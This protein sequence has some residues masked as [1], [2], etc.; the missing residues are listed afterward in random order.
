MINEISNLVIELPL[1]KKNVAKSLHIDSL[2]QRRFN[3]TNRLFQAGKVSLLELQ[4]AQTEKNNATR[5]YIIALRLF[6]ESYYLLK[7]KTGSN[8]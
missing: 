6:W 2:S 4:A 7:M 3:I 5:N 1:L 8:F